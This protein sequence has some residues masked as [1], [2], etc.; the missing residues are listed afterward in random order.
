LLSINE[1]INTSKKE[2]GGKGR[3]ERMKELGLT[4]DDRDLFDKYIAVDWEFNRSLKDIPRMDIAFVG[5][6]ELLSQFY[7]RYTFNPW[8]LLAQF[9][10]ISLA[11]VA[12]AF[13]F[14]RLFLE[15]TFSK[16]LAPFMATTDLSTGLRM[17]A[18]IKYILINYRALVLIQLFIQI[19]IIGVGW[20]TAQDFNWVV[21]CIIIFRMSYFLIDG[22][23][24]AKRILGIDLGVQDGWRVMMG[25]MAVGT[26]GAKGVGLATKGAS[27]VA[28]K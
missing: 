21:T 15:I 23:E 19:Y 6:I 8:S 16:I 3:D 28:E 4:N 7:Y 9:I 20:L 13:K 24:V 17:K 25:A 1:K 26:A 11:L 18:L 14:V 22:P 12:T 5:N 2:V 27:G 10:A